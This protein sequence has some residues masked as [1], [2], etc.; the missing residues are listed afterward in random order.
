[1]YTL[2]MY[3]YIYIYNYK[4]LYITHAYI[5]TCIHTSV[6][7]YIYTLIEDKMRWAAL[8]WTTV[9][10]V[11]C[12]RISHA[13]CMYTFICVWRCRRPTRYQ[14]IQCSIVVAAAAQHGTETL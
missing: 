8:L 7:T 13:L 4:Y 9:A 12:N 10:D 1:M 6:H 3:T 14:R 5:V 11:S 2:Y